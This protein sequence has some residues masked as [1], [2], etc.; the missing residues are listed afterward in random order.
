MPEKSPRRDRFPF[1]HV[2]MI[3]NQYGRAA[4]RR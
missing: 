1:V 3:G 4:L 2:L